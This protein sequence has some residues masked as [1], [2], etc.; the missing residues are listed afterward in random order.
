MTGPTRIYLGCYGDAD[1]ATIHV[2]DFDAT[3][4]Q[5]APL[6]QFA[7]IVNASYV[8]PDVANARLYAVSETGEGEVCALAIG[9]DGRLSLLN[10]QASGGDSPCYLSKVGNALLVANYFGHNA[11]LLPLAA[12]GLVLP[13]AGEVRHN[14]ASHVNA[15]RQD[16]PHLHSITPSPDGRYA[17]VLD[18]GRDEIAVYRIDGQQLVPHG[19]TATAP[20][21]GPRHLVFDAAG[22][23]AYVVNE[24]TSEIAVYAWHDGQLEHRQ[25]ISSLPVGFE[26]DNTGAE[27]QL[28]PDGTFLYASNRGHDSI[29][30]FRVVDGLL[31][32]AGHVPCGGQMPRNFALSPCGRWLLVAN[33]AS[34]VL[35]L[36]ARDIASGALT[37]TAMSAK[38]DR[39]VCVKFV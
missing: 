10:R 8:L 26:G 38:L 6:Q 17:L 24:L 36:F 39:P 30:I 3:S 32:A 7:G 16:A 34:G 9:S 13:M 37:Q 1:E 23:F 20:G 22:R 11:A 33:Q 25:T 12:D 2:Y 35:V 29:A 19:Q 27:L 4:G 28:S 21:A 18:L 15:E 31:E 14:G 5:M